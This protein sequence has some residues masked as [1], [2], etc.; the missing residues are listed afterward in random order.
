[1]KRLLIIAVPVAVALGWCVVGLSPLEAQPSPV[2]S[3]TATVEP[4]SGP[5]GTA[6]SD[7]TE[8]A[9]QDPAETITPDASA[10][11]TPEVADTATAPATET[12]T[13][14]PT[15][16]ATA[17]PTRVPPA[18]HLPWAGR[19]ADSSPA[20]K[21]AWGLQFSLEDI[22]D[23]YEEYAAVDLPRAR[24]YGL[25]S[26]RTHLRWDYVEPR[27]VGPDDF[28]WRVYDDRLT[29]YS[30][31]GMDLMVS[32]V[33][34]PD[35]ATEYQCGGELRPG[36]DA[37]WRQ[38]VREAAIRYSRPPFDV[39]AWEIGNEVDGKT[40]IVAA[41]FERSADW[42]GGQ[43]TTPYGGCWGDRAPA[44]VDFL[45]S[46]YEEIK[47]VDPDATVTHG[48]LA[49]VDLFDHFGYDLFHMDFLDRFLQAGGGAYID[50][51]NYHWF[52]DVDPRYQPPGPERHRQLMAKLR[53]HEGEMP[54]WLTET[55][56]LSDPTS[57]EG[58]LRQIDFATRE[59]VEMLAFPEIERVYWYGWVDFPAR[60]KP[61]GDA[62][63]RGAVRADHSP[64][65]VLSVLPYTI[66]F[67][68][69][70]PEDI[71][72]ADVQAYRFT[73]PRSV[74]E[75]VIAWT[76]RPGD[77]T[78]AVRAAPDSQGLALFFPRDPKLEIP[79]IQAEVEEHGGVIEID[80]GPDPV[81]LF[82]SRACDG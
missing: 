16:T 6:T 68:A 52:P 39:V 56:R 72:T 25:T 48:G 66:L 37:E 32:I 7:R 36:M 28:D 19:S 73:W 51:F 82:I 12:A 61:D 60:F 31:A 26:V 33:A 13:A 40:A 3:Q 65:P 78:F 58:E 17:A 18:I 69:G 54:V 49:Y 8:T 22:P 47:S 10:T 24:G 44:Y 64:K 23:L 74:Y 4:T 38:F 76:R 63:D 1:M 55:Y 2:P 71:S 27:N 14:A 42:G 35:W 62:P 59:I 50:L 80:V 46:A 75:F 21:R 81:F 41:D 53:R 57:A 5:T 79:G 20:M 43:P 9:T 77:A 34:Y 15:D 67:T 11:A 29:T 45:K 70:R 30:D